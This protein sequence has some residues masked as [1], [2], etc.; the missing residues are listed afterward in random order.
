MGLGYFVRS[1]T[2]IHNSDLQFSR[3]INFLY[4][5]YQAA[6]LFLQIFNSNFTIILWRSIDLLSTPVKDFV[7]VDC[8]HYI[9]NITTTRDF[10]L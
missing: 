9:F 3:I 4:F 7:N 5:G 2:N 8:L 10:Q 6:V 1:Q